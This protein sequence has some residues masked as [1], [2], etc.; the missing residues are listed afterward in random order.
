M[1]LFPT[2]YLSPEECKAGCGMRWWWDPRFD[3]T[4]GERMQA[5]VERECLKCNGRRYIITLSVTEH[6]R[7][8]RR[9]PIVGDSCTL[10]GNRKSFQTVVTFEPN[11]IEESKQ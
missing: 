7:S 4:G 2:T 10:C 6:E 9:F 3:I 8:I 5:I 1:P 11:T